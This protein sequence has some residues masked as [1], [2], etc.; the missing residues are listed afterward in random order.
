MAKVDRTYFLACAG[1]CRNKF[2]IVDHQ[3]IFLYRQIADLFTKP[4][5]GKTFQHFHIIEASCAIIKKAESLAAIAHRCIQRQVAVA[6]AKENIHLTILLQMRQELHRTA[7]M[8]IAG[9][10]YR[11]KYSHISS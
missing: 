11:I 10:L 3:V 5:R 6:A 9:S 1:C 8:P 2:K 7:D 4:D